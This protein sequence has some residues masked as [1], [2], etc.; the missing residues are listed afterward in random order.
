[1]DIQY[2]IRH[3]IWFSQVFSLFFILYHIQFHPSQSVVFDII[4]IGTM[5]NI[6][7]RQKAMSCTAFFHVFYAATTSPYPYYKRLLHVLTNISGFSDS[8]CDN[9]QFHCSLCYH[10]CLLLNFNLERLQ[11]SCICYFSTLNLATGCRVMA[12]SV[13]ITLTFHTP[14]PWRF[15]QTYRRTTDAYISDAEYNIMYNFI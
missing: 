11:I 12:A 1:M 7:I 8:H 2:S 10:N 6:I 5:I 13:V 14:F 3:N 4:H 9:F 15:R